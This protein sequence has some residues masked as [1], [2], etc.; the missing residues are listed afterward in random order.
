MPQCS[1]TG[2]NAGR[3]HRGLF[4][5][6]A[7]QR[8]RDGEGVGLAQRLDRLRK[9]QQFVA[10][11]RAFETPAKIGPAGELAVHL[12]QEPVRVPGTIVLRRSVGGFCSHA[13]TPGW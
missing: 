5:P 3:Q 6:Q 11:K 9:Q 2:R 12:L 7:N 13:R 10:R 8:L 4:F 1:N